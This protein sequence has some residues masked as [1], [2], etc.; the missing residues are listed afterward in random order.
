MVARR[1]LTPE[2]LMGFDHDHQSNISESPPGVEIR[3]ASEASPNDPS[4][5]YRFSFPSP[6]P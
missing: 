1:I 4:L 6:I 3:G 2:Q 5:A